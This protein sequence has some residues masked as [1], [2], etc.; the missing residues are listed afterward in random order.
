MLPISPGNGWKDHPLWEGRYKVLEVAD[1]GNITLD[2]GG[3]SK[4]WLAAQLKKRASKSVSFDAPPVVVPRPVPARRRSPGPPVTK[5]P[6]EFEIE[7]M[8]GA[9]GRIG[10]QHLIRVQWKGY[11]YHHNSWEL[12]KNL[13]QELV[14]EAADHWPSTPV[15]DQLYFT[16]L[17][18]TT[19][20]Q[21]FV[22]FSI[23]VVTQPSYGCQ[24]AMGL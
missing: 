12:S 6:G 19:L 18:W 1:D 23:P 5:P 3:P 4:T 16:P 15:L 21:S 17:F 11:D 2:L 7:S 13:S 20:S 24:C 9:S 14:Q 22:L 10:P 8:Y